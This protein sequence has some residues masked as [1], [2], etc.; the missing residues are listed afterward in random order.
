MTLNTPLVCTLLLLTALPGTSDANE[1]E[2]LQQVCAGCHQGGLTLT[3]W[4]P[5]ELAQRIRDLRDGKAA[6]PPQPL[7]DLDDAAIAKLAAE[8]IQ[9]GPN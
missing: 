8:I 9:A 7:G 3:K 6:H 5:D 4:Q 2:D 1:I